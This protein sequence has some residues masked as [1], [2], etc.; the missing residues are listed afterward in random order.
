[1]LLL[2]KIKYI[3]AAANINQLLTFIKSLFTTALV[4]TLF[5]IASASLGKSFWA[6]FGYCA[7]AQ[8]IIGYI[9]A[10]ITHSSYKNSTYL[11]ELNFLEKLSTI[12][13]C[14]YCNQPNIV[15]FLPEE[16]PNIIC[17]KCKNTS[18]I[19][20]QFSVSRTTLPVTDSVTSILKE[21]QPT[22]KIKL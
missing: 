6:G 19:K 16:I 2:T 8:F 5:G 22:H 13:N 15:T 12:L 9:V 3:F 1:M 18:S 10:T 14:A 4:S 20:L 21:P 11:A 17:E 7:A